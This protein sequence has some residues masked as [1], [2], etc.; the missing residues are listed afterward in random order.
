MKFA[1]AVGTGVA[2][3]VGLAT[4]GIVQMNEWSNK[5]HEAGGVV[6]TVYVGDTTTYNYTYDGKGNITGMY[7]VVTPQYEYYCNVNGIRIDV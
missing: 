6:E 2:S 5:C 7:P 1:I 4:F 3:I